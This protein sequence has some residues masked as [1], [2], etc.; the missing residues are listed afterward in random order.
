MVTDQIPNEMNFVTAAGTF[1][2]AKNGA[3]ATTLT[4][5][6]N[7]DQGE[8]KWSSQSDGERELQV[9]MVGQGSIITR[10][11]RLIWLLLP[12]TQ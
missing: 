10:W 2:V 5:A 3:V 12:Q 4:P 1:T 7:D 8:F 6:L 9:G 11:E